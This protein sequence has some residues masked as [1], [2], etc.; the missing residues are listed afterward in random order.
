MSE[1]PSKTGETPEPK[2][3]ETPGVPSSDPGH[4]K[5]E[6]EEFDKARAMETIRKL[7]D[8]EKL[9][10]QAAKDLEETRRKLKEFEDAQLS[11]AER[12]KKQVDETAARARELET[13]LR[14]ERGKVALTEAAA[15]IG[16]KPALA[17]RLVDLEWDGDTLKTDVKKALS[18][19]IKDLGI[20]PVTAG[21]SATTNGARGA[22]GSGE[23]DAERR[24]RL[25]G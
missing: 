23:S 18:A 15:E 3:G 9:G 10:K 13:T 19:A 25:L 11:E 4:E 24:R 21:S 1:D 12:L 14:Q 2:P 5:P 16:V 6:E 17:Q 7:R 8:Q 20:T 22:P